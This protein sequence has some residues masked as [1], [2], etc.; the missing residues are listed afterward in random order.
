VQGLGRRDEDPRTEGEGAR[1]E[2]DRI[3][4][5]DRRDLREDPPA[6]RVARTS[7][8]STLPVGEA[9]TARTEELSLDSVLGLEVLDHVL[10]LSVDPTGAGHD[11]E[12]KRQC[13]RHREP[14]S[15]DDVGAGRRGA[16]F[17]AKAHGRIRTGRVTPSQGGVILAAMTDKARALLEQAKKLA[18]D[19]RESLAYEILQ[20]IEGFEGEFTE[21]QIKEIERRARAALS[22]K[23]PAGDE[24]EVV[25][26][27]L[28]R[29]FADRR[30][31]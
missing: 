10:L 31:K 11:E 20:T 23:S 8:A 29:R 12:L 6:D 30:K 18:E 3:G 22:G 26:A 15:V 24:W 19:E 16:P 13:E 14:P 17:E 27:R 5:D 21:D 2:R 7:E 1:R 9:Q 4:R 25:V 28:E